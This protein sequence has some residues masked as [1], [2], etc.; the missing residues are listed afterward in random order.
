MK[1]KETLSVATSPAVT[2]QSSV[3]TGGEPDACVADRELRLIFLGCESKPPYGPYEHTASL[4]L[5]LIT[6]SLRT[7]GATNYR[8]ILDVYHASSGHFPPRHSY[9]DYDGIILPGSFSAAYDS[10]PWIEELT[11]IIQ[12]ELFAKDMP[13]LGVCF[14]HQLYAHSFDEGLA[15]KCPS[16]PQAGRKVSI[17]SVDGQKWLPTTRGFQLFYTHGDMVDKLPPHGRTLCG[18]DAV[19][20]QAAI[21]FSKTDA[22]KPVAVTFQAHPEYASSRPL[23]LDRTLNAIMDAMHERQDIT[24]EELRRAKDDAREEF[25]AVQLHSVE[26]MISVGRLLGWFPMD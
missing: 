4:F 16:G 9:A 18:T 8:V 7:I 25:D 26:S 10:D 2:L 12:E 21:Y 17:M 6:L 3:A 5:D 22:L 23:G 19:P 14:G 1:T 24:D 20:I 15:I 13:T 11:K